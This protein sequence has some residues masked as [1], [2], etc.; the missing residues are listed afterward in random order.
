MAPEEEGASNTQDLGY[1]RVKFSILSLPSLLR[2]WGWRP[3]RTVF[4]AAIEGLQILVYSQVFEPIAD[5]P[6]PFNER[7]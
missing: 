7:R 5:L 4:Y 2:T 1:A 3:D 6:Y